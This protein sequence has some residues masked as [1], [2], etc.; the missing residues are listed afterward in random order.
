MD[1]CFWYVD[2]RV[3]EEGENC[4]L[5][6]LCLRD[7]CYNHFRVQHPRSHLCSQIS[8]CTSASNSLAC[9]CK[10]EKCYSNFTNAETGFQGF[11]T[12]RTSDSLSKPSEQLLRL[13]CSPA[14]NPRN[15]LV[16]LH[17]LLLPPLPSHSPPPQL[18]LRLIL[19]LLSQLLRG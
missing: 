13:T 4:L 10:I 8:T 16:F 18:I 11:I 1:L 3:D 15:L 7:G 2:P 19:N 17:L 5:A 6:F 12:Q 9:R 14:H